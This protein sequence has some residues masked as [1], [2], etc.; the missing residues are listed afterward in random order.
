MAAS[1]R[2]GDVV[3][4]LVRSTD[5]SGTLHGF[6]LTASGTLRDPAT[7][8]AEVRST[9]EEPFHREQVIAAAA[10]TDAARNVPF[11]GRMR[12]EADGGGALVL[13][14]DPTDTD[15]ESLRVETAYV[16]P[17]GETRDGTAQPFAG[18]GVPARAGS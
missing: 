1:A 6:D 12:L 10:E 18:L 11:R 17:D 16:G 8:T 7:G 4:R 9:T 13:E 14:A 2:S 3:F 5:A 15:I